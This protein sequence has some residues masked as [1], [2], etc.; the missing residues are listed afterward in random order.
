MT[1]MNVC[2]IYFEIE[3]TILWQVV[4]WH[5]YQLP[6][7]IDN[8]DIAFSEKLTNVKGSFL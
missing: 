6:H 2:K 7:S 1:E 4:H 5:T 3:K 8:G